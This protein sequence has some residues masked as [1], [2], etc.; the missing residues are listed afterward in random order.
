MSSLGFG[1]LISEQVEVLI[2]KYS[3]RE[4]HQKPQ[5]ISCGMEPQRIRN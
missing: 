5:A 2:E 4:D 1:D 3:L